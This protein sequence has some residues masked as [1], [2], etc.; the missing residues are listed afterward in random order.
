MLP[1]WP[2]CGFSYERIGLTL[3]VVYVC[4]CGEMGKPKDIAA[5]RLDWINHVLDRGYGQ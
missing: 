2:A 4:S 1:N 3:E 5:A